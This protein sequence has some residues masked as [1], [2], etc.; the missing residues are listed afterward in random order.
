LSFAL[1]GF[2]AAR[3][4]AVAGRENGVLHGGMVWIVTTVLM[5]VLLGNGIGTLLNVA[6]DVATT[7]ASI[8]APVAAEVGSDIAVDPALQATASTGATQAAPA[9][10]DAVT[11]AQQQ[12]ENITPEQVNDTVR[13]LGP[14]AWVALLIAGLTAAAALIG[15]VLGTRRFLSQEISANSRP[16]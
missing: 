3:T 12:L 14:A 6:G 10:Q 1:G 5:V 13:D 8:A 16:A 9:V 7:T 15:G 11:D 2:M 4:A